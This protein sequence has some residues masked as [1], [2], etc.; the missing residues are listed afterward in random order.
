[1]G[2]V[3][4]TGGNAMLDFTSWL[5]AQESGA[6]FSEQDEAVLRRM[7]RVFGTVR[8]YSVCRISLRQVR[9]VRLICVVDEIPRPA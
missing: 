3:A 6:M 8:K 9:I 5:D 2:P 4:A 7:D 1:M